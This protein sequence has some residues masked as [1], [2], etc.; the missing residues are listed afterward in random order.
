MNAHAANPLLDFSGLPRFDAIRPAHVTPAV[1][2]LLDGRPRRRRTRGDGPGTARRGTASSSRSRTRSTAST[3][4]GAPSR[5]LNAVVNTPELR[6]AYNA[7]LPKIVAFHTDLAQ[8]LRLYAK[9]RALRDAPA[10][11]ALDPAKRKLIDNELRDF[12]LGGAELSAEH[13]ASASRR[14]KEELA[15]LSTRFEEHVLDAINAWAHY[16][17]DE[18]ELAGVPADVLAAGA[19]RGAGRRQAGLEAHVADALLPAGDAVRAR[20]A[21]CVAACTRP[22]RRARPTSA[23]TRNGTTGRSSS[24]SSCCAAK[25]R[26]C[27]AIATSPRSRW[28][29]RWR[30]PRPR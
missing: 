7:N 25:R 4:R 23:R 6:D 9:Y 13:K 15:D 17:D 27:S 5:H 19:R 29:R 24:A 30:K 2:A 20:T 26:C 18:A 1:D 11:A 14:V 3:A 8:D 21:T 22:T 28:C 12:K 16:V 10:F